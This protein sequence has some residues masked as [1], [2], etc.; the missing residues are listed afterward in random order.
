MI[1]AM[2]RE[3]ALTH[4]HMEPHHQVKENSTDPLDSAVIDSI[5]FGGGTPS[6][7]GVDDIEKLLTTTKNLYAVSDAAEITVEVNPDDAGEHK[8][9]ALRKAGVNR[10]SA[11]IQSFYERDLQWM[12]RAHS[13]VQAVQC[14][15][16][17]K[18]AGFTNYSVD[19]IYGSPTL[20]DHQWKENVDTVLA[21]KVPHISCYALTVEP[22][23]ALHKMI[24]QKKK[25]DVEEEKQ[26]RHFLMLMK[27]LAE[28]GYEHYEISNFALPGF[29]S[30]HNSS[31]WQRKPYIGIGPS[32]HSYFG[33][34]RR[35]NISN[36]SLYMQSVYKG[37]L[38]FGEEQLTVVQQLN[39]Y[40]MTSL[41]TLEGLDLDFVKERFGE[42]ASH[43]IKKESARFETSGKLRSVDEKLVLTTRGK[44]FA[45]GI[46]A[47]LFVEPG[48]V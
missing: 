23:T 39:E 42:K 36:N 33:N 35:Y 9:A 27:W 15:P 25:E 10:L 43:K 2:Q 8:M 5:Y 3:L 11:G 28:A 29:R 21:L 41:R 24:L 13:A 22:S 14:I 19:L 16:V 45:D 17:I 12:N 18:K 7:L 4:T 44:L 34:T 46:A 20:E 31:Y 48:Y 40:T 6:L 47:E 1:A 37:I 38:P 32:A 26:A 30:R